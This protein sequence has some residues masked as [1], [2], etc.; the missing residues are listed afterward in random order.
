MLWIPFLL[1]VPSKAAVQFY[2][3]SSKFQ[4][5]TLSTSCRSA[6]LSSL[7][8]DPDLPVLPSTPSASR[9]FLDAVCTADCASSLKSYRTALQA[10][11]PGDNFLLVAGDKYPPT[12]PVDYYSYYYNA[13]CLKTGQGYCADEAGIF[14]NI[15]QLYQNTSA[16]VDLPDDMLCDPCFL[17]AA[18]LQLESPYATTPEL[19]T[20]WPGIQTRCSSTLSYVPPTLTIPPPSQYQFMVVNGTTEAP[21]LCIWGTYN[22]KEGDTCQSIA[23]ERSIVIDQLVALNSLD[24]DCTLLP[25]RVGSALC[26]P[27]QC[28]LYT[29]KSGDTCD[30]IATAFKLVYSQ[31]LSL[32]FQLDLACRTLP[33]Y[34]NSTICVGLTGYSIPTPTQ[35]PVTTATAPAATV[36][37]VPIA[38]STDPAECGAWHVIVGGD[39]CNQLSLN[40]QISLLDLY[41]LNPMLNS[42]CTNLFLGYS[43]CVE[44]FNVTFA[45][46][47]TNTAVGPAAWPTPTDS[48]Y[49][50]PELAPGT[51]TD[52]STWWIP[53]TGISCS[54]ALFLFNITLAELQF[55][56]LS[57]APNCDAALRLDKTIYCV[58]DG[59]PLNVAPGTITEG[60]ANFYVPVAGDSCSTIETRYNLTL[61]MFISMNPEID[62]SCDNLALGLAYCVASTSTGGPPDNVAPGTITSGCTEYYTVLSGDSCSTLET[63]FDLTLSQFIS[64][65]PEIDATCANLALGDAYCVRS[66]NAT[67]PA[68]VAPGTITSGC[69]QY[70]T[71]VSGDSCTTVEDQFNLVLAE[72][73]RMNPEINENCS[74]LLLDEAYCV[75]SSNSTIPPNVAPG[76]ITSGC[77]QY[78]TVVSGDSCGAIETK[79]DLTSSEF[80]A[81]NPEIDA[82]CTTLQLAEAY[83]VQTSNTT[84]TGPPANLAAGSLANCTAYHTV[85][86]GDNCQTMEAAGGIAASDFFRWNPE[87]K[88][89]CTNIF[90]GEAYCVGGGGQACGKTYVVKSGDGCSSIIGAAGITQARLN[91]LN[92][93]L[94]ANCD[95]LQVGEIL[96]IG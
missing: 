55:W 24:Q 46:S 84:S 66:S 34:V 25:D 79:F 85:A 56:N 19:A 63:H 92:P 72:F 58:E 45:D 80:I 54:E 60:C 28:Q 87:V 3:S 64:M 9:L 41:Q 52:C 77:T 27:Q 61:S 73:I 90:A 38:P 39:T 21:S 43:Y 30:S 74:N 4:G 67:V 22:V 49:V 31:V 76:T 59:P 37:G 33:D 71:I 53:R 12:F 40:Y 96:C 75:K 13:T 57:L 15:T 94:D 51:A 70:Y 88:T 42:N 93:Q 68:N 14:Y 18:Q 5:S 95:N 65:N 32:N 2:T 20:N 89:D 50:E 83:C 62:A 29:V 26:L 91:A 48:T 16:Y 10:S 78:Y 35:S 1:V 69:I 11:C 81:M 6:L 7:N 47:P 82:A 86:S 8:C 17:E 23:A 36:T 44:G